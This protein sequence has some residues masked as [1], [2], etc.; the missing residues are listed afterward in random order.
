[1]KTLKRLLIVMAVLTGG[2]ILT[3][4]IGGDDNR[5]GI[6]RDVGCSIPGPDGYIYTTTDITI[7]NHGGNVNLICK[8]KG[9]SN[10]TGM[11]W[12]YWGFGCGIWDG[13]S[14]SWST[15]NSYVMVSADGNA[16]L[17]C[18]VKKEK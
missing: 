9:A 16:T 5:A 8:A 13:E 17:R 3:G 4:F 6:L 14:S 7:F 2:L 10:S 18:Q 1:M 12:E 15:N 11:D